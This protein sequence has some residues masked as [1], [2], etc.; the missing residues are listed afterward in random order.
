MQLIESIVADATSI[1]AVRRDL[2]AH[3]ELCFEETRTSDLIARQLTD[4]GIEVHRGLGKTGVVGVIRNGS[5]SRA[6]GLRADIDALPMTEHNR[7]AHA[8]RHRR[9]HARV[10]PR[11]PHRD[12]AGSGQVPRCGPRLRWHGLPRVP[13]GRGGRRWRAGDDQGRALRPFPDGSDLWRPQLAWSRR[14]AIRAALR[15]GLR[16]QQ[17]IPGSSS[18]ARG[19]TGRCHTT[20]STR[21]PTACQMVQAFQ[22]ILTRNTHPLDTGVISVTNDP[23]RRGRNVVPDHCVVE[24]T[25]RTFSKDVLGA[26][27][28]PHADD[29]RGDLCGV[30]CAMRIQFRRQLPA[31]YNHP[32]ETDFLRRLLAEVVGR[33]HVLDLPADDGRRGFQFFLLAKPGAIS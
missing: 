22:T 28:A 27:R 7:F 26:D 16:L 32:A 30:R 4:W 1:A 12:A 20:A 17:R 8:S 6:I 25:V 18:T 31:T 33:G 13:A 11:W 5:S 29:C 24:G 23:R 15:P 9:T 10:R 2:H 3:P 14:R 19:R 21:C